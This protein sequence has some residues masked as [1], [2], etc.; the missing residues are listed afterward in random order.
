MNSVAPQLLTQEEINQRFDMSLYDIIGTCKYDGI[1]FFDGDTTI[2]GNLD[3]DAVE[4]FLKELN[5]EQSADDLLVMVN[6]NITVSGRVG[7]GE[8]SPHLLVLGS[9]HCEVLYSSDDTMFITGDAHVKYAY[10][11][12]YN[13]GCIMVQGN[14]YVPYVVNS[15]HHSD[16]NPRGAILINRYSDHNDFFEYD[17][18]RE[19]LDESVVPDALD[20]KGEFDVWKFIEVVKQGLSPFKEG[21]K[22]L[23]IQYEEE[24]ERI[25]SGN[26]DTIEELDWSDKKLKVFPPSL[27]RL[28]KLKKLNLSKK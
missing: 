26:T 23:R 13:D 4:A 24:L 2:A 9:V 15:D 8:Y 27:A 1:L 25:T 14:T 3:R 12:Y 20:D 5:S 16:I 10:Y 28:K 11:G 19:V 22:P 7:M 18:T 17:Y 21:V 6:G